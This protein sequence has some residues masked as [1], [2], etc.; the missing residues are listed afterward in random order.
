MPA[1]QA[2]RLPD[3]DPPHLERPKV[4]LPNIDVGNALNDAAEAIGVRKRRRSPWPLALVGLSVAGATWVLMTNEGLRTRI[5]QMARAALDRV[6][7]WQR[8][9]F[10]QAASGET[11]PVA[12]TAAHT[13]PLSD[14]RWTESVDRSPDYPEGLGSDDPSRPEES[15]LGV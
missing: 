5:G 11:E 8:D 6:T 9:T 3:I 10:G 1:L 14:D 7:S 12:F 4:D 15:A 13:R 2:I